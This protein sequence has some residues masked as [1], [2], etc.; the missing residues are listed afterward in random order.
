MI[1]KSMSTWASPIV[2]VN[3]THTWRCAIAV[4]LVHR[5]QE[6]KLLTTSSNSSKEHKE[7]HVHTFDLAKIDE[8]FALLKGAKYLTAMDPQGDYYHIKSDDES[9]PKSTFT[10]LFGKFEFLILAFGLSQGPNLIICLIYNLF[11]LYKAST[12]GQGSGYMAY[13][14]DILIYSR[15]EKEHLEMIDKAFQYLHKAWL[16]IKLSK[17]SFFKEQIHYLGHLVSGTSIPP[18]ADKIEAL[19]KLKLPTNIKKVR[20]FL[21]L[22]GYYCN[23]VCSYTDIAYPLNCLTHKAQPFLWTLECQAHF[24]MLHLRLVNTPLVQLPDPNKP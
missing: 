18:L 10:T 22:T 8:L 12:Q 9:I 23:S 3:K 4:L 16:R 2:I 17:W 19:M 21:G 6:I 24:E 7:G 15:T 20:H 1:C 14:D 5:L 11:G 13:L